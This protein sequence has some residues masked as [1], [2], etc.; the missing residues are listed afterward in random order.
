MRLGTQFGKLITAYNLW[1]SKQAVEEKGIKELMRLYVK[2]HQEA[3]KNPSLEDEAKAGFALMERGDKQATELWQWFKDI[4]IKELRK[5]Y[6]LMDVDF[7]L[8][9]R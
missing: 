2:F 3:E 7:G 8:L 6:D 1:G 5:V 4:S 9:Y